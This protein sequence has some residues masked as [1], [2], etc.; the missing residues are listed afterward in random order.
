MMMPQLDGFRVTEILTDQPQTQR[1]PIF[2]L[3]CL[4]DQQY[5]AYGRQLGIQ[6][7]FV[8]PLDL[9]ELAARIEKRLTSGAAQS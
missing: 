5:V 4:R 9:D 8:K 7:Y 6:D 1:T 3:T 2:M